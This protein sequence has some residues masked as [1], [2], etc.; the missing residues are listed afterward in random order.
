MR[1]VHTI[2]RKRCKSDEVNKLQLIDQEVCQPQG[3]SRGKLSHLCSTFG[4]FES[5]ELND[6]NEH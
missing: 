4:A 2:T 6:T 5:F 1:R 3:E